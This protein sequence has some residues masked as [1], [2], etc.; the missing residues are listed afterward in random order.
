MGGRRCPQ[1]EMP[2]A[3][4]AQCPLSRTPASVGV[5]HWRVLALNRS[6]LPRSRP[7][8]GGNSGGGD[9][10][11]PVG[12]NASAHPRMVPL[13]PW[14]LADRLLRESRVGREAQGDSDPRRSAEH[15]S[16][17]CAAVSGLNGPAFQI[18]NNRGSPLAA[19][20]SS[21][22][23]VGPPTIEGGR[24]TTPPARQPRPFLRCRHARP[25]YGMPSRRPLTANT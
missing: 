18:F 17:G 24:P 10:T 8:Q 16:L 12:A 1:T 15:A 11:L 25:S 22:E 9:A 13:D 3:R 20:P 6:V 2:A 5:T 7:R 21:F 4:L 14:R 19:F 23:P